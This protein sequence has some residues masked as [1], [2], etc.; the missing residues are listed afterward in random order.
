MHVMNMQWDKLKEFVMKR[1]A[2]A[3]MHSPTANNYNLSFAI[4]DECT[5]SIWKSSSQKV[6]GGDY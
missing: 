5:G 3:E 4:N 6:N 2:I 1:V